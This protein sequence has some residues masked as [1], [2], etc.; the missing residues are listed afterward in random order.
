MRIG[1]F[2]G[3]FD[4]VHYGHLILA[5]LCCEAANLDEVRLVPAAVPPHKQGQG[6]ASAENRIAM[7]KLAIG[8]NPKLNVWDEEIRRG[9]ISYTVDTLRS[10]NKEHDGKADLFFLM[11][12]DSLFDLPNWREPAEICRLASI[13]V[14]DRPGSRAVDFSILEDLVDAERLEEFRELAVEIPQIDISS[15]RLRERIQAGKSIRYQTPR[16]VE[17]F[18]TSADLYS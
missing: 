14:V 5:E 7:L 16:P 13:V 17:A 1:I 10:L 12:A 2:G 9:G 8:G 15:S 3:S 4:P 6:R 11:G 18:I